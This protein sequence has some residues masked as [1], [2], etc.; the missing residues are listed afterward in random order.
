M[1]WKAIIIYRTV[2]DINILKT[3]HRFFTAV[4]MAGFTRYWPAIDQTALKSATSQ[5][6]VT[7]TESEQ[8]P[9]QP[10]SVGVEL[11]QIFTPVQT[12][13]QWFNSKRILI[14]WHL[15]HAFS[16]ETNSIGIK[17]TQIENTDII[18]ITNVNLQLIMIIQTS[19]V[20]IWGCGRRF[21]LSSNLGSSAARTL[22]YGRLPYV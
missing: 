15:I 5:D 9:C 1:W 18:I 20:Q 19:M 10:P 12:Q 8:Q 21:P 6:K 16:T 22:S 3:N 17:Q 13:S 4:N 14:R 2:L 7:F 11:R